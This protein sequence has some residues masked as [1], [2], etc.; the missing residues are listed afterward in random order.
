MHISQAMKIACKILAQHQPVKLAAL[1]FDGKYICGDESC[2]HTLAF[3]SEER[4][5][6]RPESTSKK[7]KVYPL[8]LTN[9]D[10]SSSTRPSEYVGR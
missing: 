10:V 8:D 9:L 1:M 6:E 2:R 3:F 5:Q 4:Q 7:K